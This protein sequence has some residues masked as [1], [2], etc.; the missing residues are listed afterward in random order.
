MKPFHLVLRERMMKSQT[1]GNISWEGTFR[2]KSC[3]H[4]GHTLYVYVLT[5]YNFGP[6]SPDWKSCGRCWCSS[7]YERE[8]ERDVAKTL[9]I[10]WPICPL[11]IGPCPVSTVP[12]FFPKATNSI[13]LCRPSSGPFKL[14]QIKRCVPASEN[15]RLA[16]QIANRK[17]IN[18]NKYGK[19]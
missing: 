2:R 5:S 3:T 8:R 12:S 15:F 4:Q 1:R 9:R 10:L 16:T 17:N 14:A 11:I 6:S 19:E 18:H 13:T 7:D